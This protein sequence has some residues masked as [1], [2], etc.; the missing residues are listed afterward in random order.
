MAM[1]RSGE[2]PNREAPAPTPATVRKKSRRLRETASST[3]RAVLFGIP[4][5]ERAVSLAWFRS[6]TKTGF[7]NKLLAEI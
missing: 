1:A 2:K 3:A 5:D 4:P 6:W 7:F